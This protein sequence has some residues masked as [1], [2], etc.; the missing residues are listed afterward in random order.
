MKNESVLVMTARTGQRYV[1]LL[2]GTIW[3]MKKLKVEAK[4]TTAH[5]ATGR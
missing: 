5:I 3:R 2:D 1:M 4:L